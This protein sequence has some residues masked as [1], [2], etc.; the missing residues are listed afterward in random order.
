M[1]ADPVT[2][3]LVGQTFTLPTASVYV[4][5]ASGG[6][7]LAAPLFAGIEAQAEQKAGHPLGFTNPAIYQAAARG[8]FRDV[9]DT[10]PGVTP[11]PAA[12]HT[13]ISVSPT[14]TISTSFVLA[15]FG[16]AQ[17]TG[18]ATTTGYD[19]VTGVGSP[20]SRTINFPRM[21]R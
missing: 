18:L 10:P 14:G 9:T 16:R 4:E 19:D 6:T 11:P 20:T 2:G 15:T 13:V 17:D 8:G 3:M 7:S 21:S 12:V 1:D 5:F